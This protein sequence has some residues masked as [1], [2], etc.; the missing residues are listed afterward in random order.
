[1]TSSSCGA[2]EE[3]AYCPPNRPGATQ[4]DGDCCRNGSWV[5]G[6]C[7]SAAATDVNMRQVRRQAQAKAPGPNSSTVDRYVHVAFPTKK[8]PKNN[9]KISLYT[10]P[11]YLV[12]SIH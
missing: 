5:P 7:S 1:M 10:A 11:V 9:P 6:I 2:S 8:Q 4:P 12:D 3:G